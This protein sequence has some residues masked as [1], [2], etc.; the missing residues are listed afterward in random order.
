MKVLTFNLWNIN[1]CVDERMNILGKYLESSRPDVISFQE[2]SYHHSQLQV[3]NILIRLNYNY[4]YHTAHFWEGREEG[5]IVAS[6]FPIVNKDVINLPLAQNDENRIALVVKLQIDKGTAISIIN[7]HLSYQLDNRDDR[8]QQISTILAHAKSLIKQR[9][10]V[11]LCGDFNEDYKYGYVY[12]EI[13]NAGFSDSW[14]NDY[15]GITFSARNPYVVPALWPDRRLDYI[16]HSSSIISN[17]SSSI[18]MDSI[19]D[20]TICS[21]HYGLL[22]Y[23]EVI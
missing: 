23:L 6:R 19:I 17:Q 22:S 20:N 13:I 11:I 16:F 10:P 15:K 21:D 8:R 2:V 4:E 7:T 18:V 14:T 1:E 12:D 3:E 5:L 9:E